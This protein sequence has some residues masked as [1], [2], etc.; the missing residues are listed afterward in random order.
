MEF[1]MDNHQAQPRS[2][3]MDYPNQKGVNAMVD[4]Q[5]RPMPPNGQKPPATDPR[6][7][8]FTPPAAPSYSP[9][10]PQSS[11]RRRGSMFPLV[12]L[13]VLIVALSGG[14]FAVWRYVIKPNTV[15]DVVAYKISAQ[16]VPTTVG[17]SGIIYPQNEM[18]VQYPE[19]VQVNAVKVQ[20]GQTVQVGTP[21][22]SLDVGQLASQ[23][24]LAQ[25][26]VA[27]LQNLVNADAVSNPSRV[28]SD[29]SNLQ[30]AESELQQLQ[31]QQGNFSNGNLTSSMNGVVTQINVNAGETVSANT[32]LLTIMD[33][34]NVVV[35]AKIPLANMGQVKVGQTATV[36][37]SAVSNLTVNGK[38]TQ[39]VPEADPQTDTFEVWVT[40]PNTTQQLLAGMSAFVNIQST[41]STLLVPRLAVLNQDSNP[42]VFV[43]GTDGRAHLTSVHVAGRSGTG[44]YIYVDSGLTAN[45]EVVV[46]GL[47]TLID[48]QQIKVDSVEP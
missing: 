19:A 12:S 39:V 1:A 24:A 10:M 29:Q 16:S 43:V 41:A 40:I 31:S 22:M 23:I 27:T 42:E 7:A 35:H 15:A 17:G 38:V 2:M 20:A 28:P 13:I 46:Q 18:D 30:L 44:D 11:Q 26:K 5:G 14:T 8:Y 36:S 33:E 32:P 6:S 47:D 37:A 4:Q 3:R 25:A 48:N 21:L 34:S 45:Q 9:S